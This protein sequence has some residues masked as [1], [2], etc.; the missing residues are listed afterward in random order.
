MQIPMK[1]TALSRSETR[2]KQASTRTP[3]EL[4]ALITALITFSSRKSK[5]TPA[6][7]A[8]KEDKQDQD[9]LVPGGYITYIVW[10]VV[11]GVQL[12]DGFTPKD[13]NSP[14]WSFSREE[15]DVIRDV[16]KQEYPYVLSPS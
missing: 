9:G 11:P 15:R 14:F 2:A 8:Y 12:G 16:F 10:E 1:G 4:T 13:G 3:V 7:L 5:I 6:L